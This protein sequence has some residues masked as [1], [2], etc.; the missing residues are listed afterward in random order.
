M[1]T[2]RR[3]PIYWTSDPAKDLRIQELEDIKEW[4]TMWHEFNKKAVANVTATAPQK[5]AMG[6]C[7]HARS[8]RA[9]LQTDVR[10]LLL[11]NAA[12]ACLRASP[13]HSY[14]CAQPAHQCCPPRIRH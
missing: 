11:T 9:A 10:L 4:V 5:A 1:R 6:F 13:A 14:A 2:S 8:E 7:Q 12:P 3:A